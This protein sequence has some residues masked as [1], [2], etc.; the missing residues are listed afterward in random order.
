MSGDYRE[1][2]LGSYIKNGEI[3]YM[4]QSLNKKNEEMKANNKRGKKK[5]RQL[6][7]PGKKKA[8]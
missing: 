2:D 4:M 5:E 7:T 8:V 6:E 3:P 1:T